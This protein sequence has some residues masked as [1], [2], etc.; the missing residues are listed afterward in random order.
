AAPFDDLVQ[1]SRIGKAAK[2]FHDPGALGL[3][4]WKHDFDGRA[5]L[6]AADL[7]LRRSHPLEGG[8]RLLVFDGEMA[9][10]NADSDMLAKVFP[11]GLDRAPQRCR[12]QRTSILHECAVEEAEELVA[13]FDQAIRFRLDVEMNQC[14]ALLPGSRQ[15]FRDPNNIGCEWTG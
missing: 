4:A 5:E 1:V 13:R 6:H 9:A 3:V 2:A 14:A 10:V 12:Q 11:G 8:D 7:D 15:R